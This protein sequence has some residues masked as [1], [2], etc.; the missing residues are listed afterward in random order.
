MAQLWWDPKLW[1]VGPRLYIV[2]HSSPF[3]VVEP[4][5][6]RVMVEPSLII[7][8]VGTRLYVVVVVGLSL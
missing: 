7:V 3:V 2:V 4:R 1:V 5:L 6:Y 8:V